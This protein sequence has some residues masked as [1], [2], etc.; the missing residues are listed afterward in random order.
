MKAD[1]EAAR[2]GP[3]PLARQHHPHDAR[4]RH[5]RRLHRRALGHRPDLQ[6]DDLRQ[7]DLRRRRL[8]RA[9]RRGRAAGPARHRR[10]GAIF[11]ELALAD[12]RDAT[13]LFAEVHE[14]TAGVDG[15]CSLEVSPLLADDT[16]A[17]I[18]QA[19]QLH[20]KAERENL[21]IKIPGTEA[22]LPAIEE[23]IFAGIPVN[24]T[25]L[26][27]DRAVPRPPPTPTCAG[28]SGGSRPGSTPTSPRS[29]RSS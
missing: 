15:F 28:S 23:T 10:E 2:A 25:L 14:R 22:G 26:F 4:R 18:A 24:V 6:P 19:A 17:T 8:R 3:E 27:D 21:F 16:A 5:P 29:P 7:G 9:D 11:F 1:R 13:D 20:A 12:L